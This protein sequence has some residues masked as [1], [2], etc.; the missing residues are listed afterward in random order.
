MFACVCP[1]RGRCRKSQKS[2]VL[3]APLQRRELRTGLRQQG[4]PRLFFIGPGL[5]AWA[6]LFRASGARIAVGLDEVFQQFRM[7][8]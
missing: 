8:I 7:S 5:S 3:N 4:N 6:T 2:F 1:D